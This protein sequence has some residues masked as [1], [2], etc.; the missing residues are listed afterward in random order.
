MALDLNDGY[1][2]IQE[3]VSATQ[4]YK[5]IKKDADDLKKRKGESLETAKKLSTQQLSNLK[6]KRD[7]FK[8]DLNDS[9]K[10]QFDQLLDLTKLLSKGGEKSGQ[11]KTTKYLKKVFVTA[12]T[13]LK[14]QIKDILNDL[15]TSAIGCAQ[16]QTYIGNQSIYIKVKSFD[17]VNFLKEDPESSVGKIT[18]EKESIQYGTFPFSLNK[19]LYDRMQNINQPYSIPATLN[20]V[21]TSGQELF[22]IT[23]VESYVDPIV[24]LVQGNFYKIDL[25]NRESNKIVEFLEDYYSTIDIVDFKNIFANLINQLTGAISI[26]KGDGDINLGD[27]TKVLLILKRILGLCFDS[28]TE[29]DVSGVSKVSEFDNIDKSFFE[30]TEIDLRMIDQK[31]SEIKL[32]IAEFEE[33]GTVKLPVDV[34]SII[35]SVDALNYVDGKNNNNTINDAAN[36]T[37]TITNGFFPLKINIDLDFLKEFPKSLVMAILSPKVVLPIMIMAK[38]IGQTFVDEINS[39]MDF[40]EKLKTYFSELVSKIAALFVKIIFDIIKKDIKLLIAGIISDIANEKTKKRT[41]M[42]L[43]LVALILSIAKIIKDFRECKSIIND[44]QALL[45]QIQSKTQQLPLP[46][47]LATKLRKGYSKTGAFLNVISE[48]EKLGLPTGPMPDGSPNLTLI[49]VKA[50]IDGIDKE[51]TENSRVDIGIGP[52]SVTPLFQTIPKSASGLFI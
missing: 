52:L 30:F 36:I 13:E 16:D 27:L 50:I 29:I 18:Y 20:Y 48:F 44:L 39:F 21:G 4:K 8:K 1:K 23:Y 46:L 51:I 26:K 6:D 43:S 37:D 35:S 38:S 14:P 17:L 2:V 41:A 3:K 15:G 33:C 25:K 42:I 49:S 40:A 34:D 9:K 32:G 10:T 24:G 22:D 12:I 11:T 5:N 28:T 7:K 19:S 31:V 47:L 45:S